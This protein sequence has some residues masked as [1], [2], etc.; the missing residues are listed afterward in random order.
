MLTSFH[1]FFFVSFDGGE[2]VSVDKPPLGL[3]IQAVSAMIFEFR[4]GL[5]CPKPSRR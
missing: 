3:W 1:N 2:F 4:V 5:I